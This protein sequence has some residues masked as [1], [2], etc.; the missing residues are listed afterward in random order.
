MHHQSIMRTTLNIADELLIEAKRM[1]AERQCSV[2]EVVNSALRSALKRGLT[3]GGPKVRFEMPIYGR[4]AHRKAP[5]ISPAEMAALAE[6]DDLA[7]Y[8]SPKRTEGSAERSSS[9]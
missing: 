5:A 6:K 7:P 9:M 1:A 3:Q 4:K 2:S 8:R